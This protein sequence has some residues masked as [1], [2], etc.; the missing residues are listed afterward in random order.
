M[1]YNKRQGV[2]ARYVRDLAELYGYTPQQVGK[3]TVY[4][5]NVLYAKD[6]EDAQNQAQGIQKINAKSYSRMTRDERRQLMRH[7]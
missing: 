7:V 4:Q 3:L 6:G 2:I 5:V 1:P